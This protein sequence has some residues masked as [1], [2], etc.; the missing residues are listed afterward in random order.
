MSSNMNNNGLSRENRLALMVLGVVQSLCLLALH[1][2]LN[3]GL[4][5]TSSPEW[6]Y[7]LY[8][9]AI[10][11]PL[12]LYF[13]AI[14]WRDRANAVAAGGLATVLFWL[15]WQ[16]GWLSSPEGSESL[17]HHGGIASLACG[18]LLALFIL[19]FFFRTHREHH[20]LDYPALLDNSWRIAL[21][22]AF[23][24]LF[25]V[26][27][28]LLLFLW[29]ELFNVI[30]I[31]FFI[32]LFEEPEFIYPVTGLVGGWGLGLIRDREN[33]IATVRR[34][35]E[36]LT[37]ALLPLAAFILVLFLA[38]LPFT[39][40]APL[41]DTGFAASL[42]LWLATII[43]YFFNAVVAEHEQP[44]AALPW[45]RRL[46]LLTLVLLPVTVILAGW[47][48]GLRIE[49]YGLTVSRLWGLFV[50]IFIGLFSIGYAVLILRY[51]TLPI[52]RVRQ[53]NTLLG[54]V[55]ALALILVHTPFLNFY[56]LSA[57]NQ[58]ARLLDGTTTPETFDE[59]YLRFHLSTYGTR[60]LKRLESN[61][62]VAE[63]P[64]LKTRIE[65]ALA[66]R[67]RWEKRRPPEQQ[68]DTDWR[69][70]QF[71]LLPGTTISDAFFDTLDSDD[72]TTQQC[73]DG[74][75]HCVLGDF[76][77]QGEHYRAI[78]SARQ[79]WR[80]W[81]VWHQ[82]GERWERIGTARPSLCESPINV[83]LDQPFAV[84]DSDHLM[85]RNGNCTYQLSLSDD[86]IRTQFPAVLESGTSP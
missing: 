30:G 25:I 32:D 20:R 67:T 22:Q 24:L 64:E 84:A 39:G 68:N 36:I 43:L 44:F 76:T 81:P 16:A 70:T 29:A 13:G 58:V 57:N 72:Y 51:R 85:W 9:V 14:H 75:R 47:S 41:W 42:M 35:C 27:F 34:L 7:A 2:T 66:A 49:Q 80:S 15:G 1:K 48:L 82:R 52:V 19:G 71:E 21:T 86:Y 17:Q 31:G 4:W 55:L 62:F 69:R 40:V 78:T 46:L 79:H 5:P 26:V 28:W 53:W 54:G 12:F 74:L 18:L 65:Q 11:V 77:F 61:A 3:H 33:L 10:G 23:L 59:N 63:H 56:K 37:R 38:A 83:A 73:L 8:T 6:L 50:E 45:L 60:A